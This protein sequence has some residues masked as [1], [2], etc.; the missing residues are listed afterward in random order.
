MSSSND[1][2][3]TIV[4]AIVIFFVAITFV[5][6]KREMYE[7]SFEVT[8]AEREARRAAERSLTESR[9]KIEAIAREMIGEYEAD[10]SQKLQKTVEDRIGLSIEPSISE[11]DPSVALPQLPGRDPQSTEAPTEEVLARMAL[12][13]LTKDEQLELALTMSRCSRFFFIRKSIS[14]EVGTSPDEP[15]WAKLEEDSRSASV[16]LLSLT[17]QFVDNVY[18]LAEADKEVVGEFQTV[19]ER[20]VGHEFLGFLSAYDSKCFQ[21][22]Q[23]SRGVLNFR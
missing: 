22:S 10:N 6:I 13:D 4:A 21:I 18:L 15:D 11:S 17:N 3:T 1:S 12:T 9:A 20:R 19:L 7:K 8:P 23:I 14:N 2:S 16:Y 5:L